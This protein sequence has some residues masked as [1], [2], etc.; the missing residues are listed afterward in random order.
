MLDLTYE[1][2]YDDMTALA[3]SDPQKLDEIL[4]T[5]YLTHFLVDLLQ[6]CFAYFVKGNTLNEFMPQSRT[7]YDHRQPICRHTDGAD[8]SLLAFSYFIPCLPA[9]LK[10][11]TDALNILWCN[12]FDLVKLW[13]IKFAEDPEKARSYD[14]ARDS[15]ERTDLYG[16]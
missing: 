11:L 9:T 12:P 15:Y 10:E 2:Y 8:I 16:G 6:F 5:H 13:S 1:S 7:I 4:C 3:K 14:Q